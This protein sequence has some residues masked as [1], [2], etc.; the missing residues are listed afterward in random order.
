MIDVTLAQLAEI[1]GGKLVDERADTPVVHGVTI[2]SRRVGD[3]DLFVAL[4]GTRTDGHRFVDAA[5]AAGA[6]GALVAADRGVD[7]APGTAVVVVD[8]PADA[9][10]ALG[11][12]LRDTLDPHVVAV[13]GSNGKTTTKDLIAASLRDRA[14]V[15]NEGSFNNELGMPLTCCRMTRSTEVLVSEL[16]MRGPGQIAQLAALLRPTVGVVTSVAGVHLELLGSLEAIADAKGEL[17][18]ALDADGTA[19]LAADDAR[20]AAMAQRTVATV[21]TFGTARSADFRAT[22]IELDRRARP[23]FVLHSPFG[24]HDVTVPVPGMH[25]VGNALA[26]VAAA[27]ASGVDL[28]SAI[29][30]LAHAR[31]SRW[32]LQLESVGDVSI[33]NDAYNANPTSVEAALRTLRALPTTGRRWAVLGTMAEIGPTSAEEHRRTGGVVTDLGVDALIT[34]GDEAAAMI[35]GA[36]A[37][38]TGHCQHRWAVD[39]VDAA[40]RILAHETDDQDVVL[41]KASR[42][43]GLERV[44][45]RFAELRGTHATAG[46]RG[47]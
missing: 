26:A 10:L 3:G 13:T 41:V 38:D 29:A 14:V 46:G 18:E 2:D 32:R 43:A 42:S 8:D 24:R 35:E 37:A 5:L 1:V 28:S 15:A 44:V 22:D 39:D 9:L 40:A 27:T 25:N 21:V 34:V 12:W 4:P 23:R 31:V 6:A 20:V 47:A 33:L 19:V 7:P 30:G 16:G 11:A 45:A 17:V 36:A